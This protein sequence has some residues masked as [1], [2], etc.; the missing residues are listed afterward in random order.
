MSQPSSLE[1]VLAESKA[2]YE[3]HLAAMAELWGPVDAQLAG[4]G[5][6][7]DP[8]PG[9]GNCLFHAVLQQWGKQG[10]ATGLTHEI[11]RTE[12]VRHLEAN[13]GE[14]EAKMTQ[15]LRALYPDWATYLAKMRVPGEWADELCIMGLVDFFGAPLTLFTG[16]GLPLVF[17]PVSGREPAFGM[18]TIAH[19]GQLHYD[20][21]RPLSDAP[22]VGA[23]KGKA[24]AKGTAK[25]KAKAKAAAT[26]YGP[27]RGFTGGAGKRC[28]IKLVADEE[29]IRAGDREDFFAKATKTLMDGGVLKVPILQTTA[30]RHWDTLRKYVQWS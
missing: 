8:V 30:K 22:L 27:L 25:G 28:A 5:L 3:A 12:T 1:K 4:R 18:S 20:G 19:A 16:E 29:D 6:E 10:L 2:A 13:P 24:K 23:A 26:A 7:R 21:T 11:L 17:E 9:D 15:E 14:F